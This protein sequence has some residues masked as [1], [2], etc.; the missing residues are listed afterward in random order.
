MCEV[1]KESDKFWYHRL[2]ALYKLMTFVIYWEVKQSYPGQNDHIYQKMKAFQFRNITTTWSAVTM[3][4]K[5]KKEHENRAWRRIGQH[6]DIHVVHIKV[7]LWK[8][9]IKLKSNLYNTAC[10]FE[11]E[12]WFTA[13]ILVKR[14]W[15][16]AGL[17]WHKLIS[18]LID[19]IMLIIWTKLMQL[20]F[21]L[22]IWLMYLCT[23]SPTASTTW[24]D[25]N[26]HLSHFYISTVTWTF[27]HSCCM[28]NFPVSPHIHPFALIPGSSKLHFKVSLSKILNR[29]LS[30]MHW[31]LSV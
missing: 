8:E 18:L 24:P 22:Y 7:V 13:A 20:S 21:F 5:K 6:R 19:E 1:K 25:Y 26:S 10:K 17:P 31:G 27:C 16:D 29:K 15:T 2:A 9:S 30:S 14:G 3:A 12:F 4:I 23:E 11:W 28:L